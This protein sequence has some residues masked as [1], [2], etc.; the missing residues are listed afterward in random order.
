MKTVICFLLVSLFLAPQ[1]SAA[2]IVIYN[3]FKRLTGEIA[4]G[5]SQKIIT[6]IRKSPEEFGKYDWQLDSDS[7]DILEAMRIGNLIK[8]L[9]DRVNVADKTNLGARCVSAC[10]LFTSA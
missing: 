6:L 1:A 2:D 5:D 9:Y 4:G 7:G 10:F 3:S 8:E